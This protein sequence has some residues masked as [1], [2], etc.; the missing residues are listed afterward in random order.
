M[1]GVDDVVRC[2]MKFAEVDWPSAA[3]VGDVDENQVKS[4]NLLPHMPREGVQDLTLTQLNALVIGRMSGGQPT[5]GQITA[6]TV[7]AMMKSPMTGS[8][9][10]ERTMRSAA[11]R[12]VAAQVVEAFCVAVSAAVNS[13]LRGEMTVSRAPVTSPIMLDSMPFLG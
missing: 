9:N 13:S 7:A 1:C 8:K 2:G 3:G 6:H 10:G 11:A 12:G 5:A 4:N